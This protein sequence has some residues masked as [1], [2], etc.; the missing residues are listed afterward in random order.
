MLLLGMVY[1]TKINMAAAKKDKGFSDPGHRQYEIW[2]VQLD[3][4]KGSETRKTRP[5]IILQ[6]DVINRHAPTTLVAP[7]LKGLKLRLHAVNVKRSKA[8]G[9]D[10]DRRIEFLQIRAIDTSRL[11]GKLGTLEKEY[12]NLLRKASDIVFGY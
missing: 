3:P 10:E 6:Q 4:T 7:F 12:R 5:C 1:R 11:Q 8:N 2:W 9:L